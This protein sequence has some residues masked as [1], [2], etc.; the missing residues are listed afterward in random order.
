MTQED[1]IVYVYCAIEDQIAGMRLRRAGFPP[2]L[3]DAEALTL[4]VVGE[5]FGM[6]EDK[7]IWRYFKTH[8]AEWFPK[9][10]SRSAF[11]RQCANLLPL[12]QWLLSKLFAISRLSALHMQDGVP[13]PV[14]RYARARRDRCFKGEA[15][16][17]YCASKDEHY[18]GFL[19]HVTIDGEGK[20]SGFILTPAN[21]SERN[22]LRDTAV[23]MTGMMLGDKG[24]IGEPLKKELLEGGLDLQTPLRSNMHDERPSTFVKW[25]VSARRLIETVIGQLTERFGINAIRVKDFRH[26]QA[27]IARKLLAHVL[28]TNLAKSIGIRPTQLDTLVVS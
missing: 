19:G 21:G 26:L 11:V 7:T 14:I 3:S 23:G 6:H 12:K 20:L 16:F 27:R 8:Y 28:A 24:Y 18:Y 2:R 4:V 10:G 13:I 17:G 22:A 9:L 15:A 5:F 25:I 1:F